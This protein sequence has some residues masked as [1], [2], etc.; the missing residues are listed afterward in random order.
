MA[1][2]SAGL[3]G[4]MSRGHEKPLQASAKQ[5]ILKIRISQDII[6]YAGWRDIL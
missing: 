2:L 4:K 1:L 6:Q 5:Y 3:P